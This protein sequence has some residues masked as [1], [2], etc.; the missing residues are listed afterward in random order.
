MISSSAK[1]QIC[2]ITI[3]ILPIITNFT[4]KISNIGKMGKM[5]IIGKMGIVGNIGKMG[6]I[7]NNCLLV[8]QSRSLTPGDGPAFCLDVP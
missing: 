4:Y 1:L 3:A 5:G 7:G 6:I 2:T 8:I